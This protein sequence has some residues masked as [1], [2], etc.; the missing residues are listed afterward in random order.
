MEKK[1]NRIYRLAF[2][3]SLFRFASKKEEEEDKVGLN[4]EDVIQLEASYYRN[5]LNTVTDSQATKILEDLSKAGDAKS[6]AGLSEIARKSIVKENVIK[7]LGSFYNSGIPLGLQIQCAR[8]ASNIKLGKIEDLKGLNK[9]KWQQV[10]NRDKA[11]ADIDRDLVNYQGRINAEYSQ[12][13]ELY[14]LAMREEHLAKKDNRMVSR[15]YRDNIIKM[16]KS[17][18]KIFRMFNTLYFKAE[19]IEEMSEKGV[20]DLSTNKELARYLLD[21]KRTLVVL[22]N[23]LDFEVYGI[24]DAFK[25]FLEDEAVKEVSGKS[26]DDETLY[27]SYIHFKD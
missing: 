11:Q 13:K 23:Q 17:A 9:R 7:A 1:L 16:L 2:L 20:V 22:N 26:V 24:K 3:K 18:M 6:Y 25:L 12:V 21:L 10:I 8:I 5:F 27:Q 4:R 14:G 15:E 19:G